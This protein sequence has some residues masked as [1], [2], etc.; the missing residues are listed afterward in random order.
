M[1]QT[2]DTVRFQDQLSK[3]EACNKW[4]TE[5]VGIKVDDTRFEMVLTLLRTIVEHYA[6]DKVDEL[7]KE[8]DEP[9]LYYVLTDAASFMKI[10]DFF[11]V[12]KSNEIPRRKLIES[13]NGPL[14]PW[15]EDPVN[16]TAHGRNIA[17]ELET[18]ISFY[19]TGLAIE[20][21]DDVQI[22]FN[23]HHFNVQCKRLH[24]TKRIFNSIN[25]AAAQITER[26]ADKNNYKGLIYLCIEKLSETE[27]YILEVDHVDHIGPHLDRL[28]HKF[29]KENSHIWHKL[30][31]HNILGTAVVLNALARIDEK[32]YPLLTTCRHT[33]LDIIPNEGTGQ[34]YNYLL[35][36]DLGRQMVA[37]KMLIS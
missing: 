19:R 11:K 14:L 23:N 31:N 16:G 25:S 6:S 28:T 2:F 34:D 17:F 26:I 8:Y 30:L 12:K 24:S 29:I 37:T 7:L 21:Y 15:D 5:Q 4:L 32:P 27:G 18:A 3:L 9:T 1:G 10:Y 22:E 13:I 33:M 35:I 36:K 20:S